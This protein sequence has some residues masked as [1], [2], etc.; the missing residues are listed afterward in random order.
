MKW[1]WVRLD[2]LTALHREQLSE[3][4]G[5]DGVRDQGMLES[6]LARA[7]NIAAYA[8]PTAFE[9]AASYAFGVI[10]NHPFVDGNKRTGFIAA[11]MFLE[12]NGFE[13]MASEID[14][15]EKTLAAAAGSIDE[16][17]YALSLQVNS[18]RL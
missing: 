8:Q 2:V 18:R 17:A 10:R 1:V 6:A 3:H 16:N 4:G 5:A 9:L 12:L 15:A 14:A 11:V 13:F 7:E